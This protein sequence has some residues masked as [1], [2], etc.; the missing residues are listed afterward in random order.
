MSSGSSQELLSGSGAEHSGPAMGKVESAGGGNRIRTTLSDCD[1]GLVSAS[2][3]KS[4]MEQAACSLAPACM[5]SGDAS[6]H[7]DN[8]IP[9]LIDINKDSGTSPAPTTVMPVTTCVDMHVVGLNT[10]NAEHK[11]VLCES[12]NHCDE[13]VTS[14]G[15]AG[16]RAFPTTVRH[17]SSANKGMLPEVAA[18]QIKGPNSAT[19]SIEKS[20]D[21]AASNIKIPTLSVCVS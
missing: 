19:S 7:S 9:I 18:S 17:L 14:S 4:V 10:L 2:S 11:N 15:D 8:S 3:S 1:G 6:P 21:D 20:G 5:F 16:V 12:S 13:T